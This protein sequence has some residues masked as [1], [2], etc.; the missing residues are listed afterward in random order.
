LATRQD[1]NQH[2]RFG[3][4]FRKF[5]DSVVE[6]FGELPAAAAQEI[7]EEP[8]AAG[9]GVV[10]DSGKKRPRP[11]A[12]LPGPSPVKKTKVDMGKVLVIS[13][14]GDQQKLLECPMLNT[15]SVGLMLHIKM[16]PKIYIFNKSLTEVTLREGTTV[17]GFGRGKF[18]LREAGD[19]NSDPDKELL[20]N[21]EGSSCMVL[22]NG[23]LTTVKALVAE[24]RKVNP[25][26]KVNYFNLEEAPTAEDPTA[27]K[28]KRVNNIF[29]V[30]GVAKAMEGAGEGSDGVG[31]GGVPRGAVS[32]S[33]RC[34]Q[35]RPVQC[36]RGRGPPIA[37][38]S[39]SRSSGRAMG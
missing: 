19:E 17:A 38:R 36:Q 23:I 30:P 1:W 33:P 2:P 10:P 24:R 25:V 12:A 31:E 15:K 34:K 35:V 9:Q 18:K 13:E 21:L 3:D 32:A 37:Q 14:V 11:N 4:D 28:L 8:P 22:H 39:F 26:V 27:F 6:E 20:Y 5:L 29:F 16:G 7:L